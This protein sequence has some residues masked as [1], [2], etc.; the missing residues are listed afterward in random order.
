M[1][2][3]SKSLKSKWG[4][5]YN[6]SKLGEVEDVILLSWPTTTTYICPGEQQEL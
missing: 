2:D 4:H 1:K 5:I 6:K 3:D